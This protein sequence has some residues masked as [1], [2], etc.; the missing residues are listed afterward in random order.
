MLM[1][2]FSSL[3]IYLILI[4]SVMISIAFLTLLERK[5]LSYIHFRKG[6]N[7]IF[8]KGMFQPF[9]DVL[10]LFLKESLKLKNLNYLI[11]LSSPIFGLLVLL[12]SWVIFPYVMN[13]YSMNL[14]MIYL[15]VIVS[16]SV[17]MIMMA[18]WSSNS[19]YSLLGSIR[20][21]AQT[22][23]Y[24]VILMLLIILELF[25]LESFNIN[26][27]MIF[28]KKCWFIFLNLLVGILVYISILAELNRTP[29]DLTEGESE[30]VSGFNVEYMSGK[31]AFIFMIEYGMIMFFMMLY[32]IMFLNGKMSNFL[33]LLIYM[34]FLM[35]LIFIR[36]SMPRIRYDKLMY[37]IWKSFL[38]Y[39]LNYYLMIYFLKFYME[40]VLN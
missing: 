15:F 14:S 19:L 1:Y 20:S 30:L 5:L 6:P 8:F 23:S 35:M 27:F 36:A 2:L 10:K 21:I 11:Y 38:P 39:C 29:F 24:E 4:I 16:M 17:Y 33:D 26:K 12:L 25:L 18:G 9:S 13:E 37:L 3:L 28:Q 22:I 34:M 32:K 40:I 31:F 7:K